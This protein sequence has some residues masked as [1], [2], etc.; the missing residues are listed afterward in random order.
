MRIP[1]A[2]IQTPVPAPLLGWITE[3]LE[4]L[5]TP[6]ADIAQMN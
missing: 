4:G 1:I 6:A 5:N 3:G 2:G